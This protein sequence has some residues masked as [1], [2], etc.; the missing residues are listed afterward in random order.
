M[1]DTKMECTRV[2]V[3]INGLGRFGLHLLQYWLDNYDDA[4]FDIVYINDEVLGFEHIK[5]IV[6]TDPY[7]KLSSRINFK[8]NGL[9]EVKNNGLKQEINY[10]TESFNSIPWLGKTSIF[11]ECSGRHTERIDWDRVIADKTKLVI[12]SA[13]SWTAD[14]I[15]VFGHNHKDIDITKRRVV[16]YGSCTVN[17]YVPLADF[18]H[19]K[20]G[21]DNSDVSVIHNIPVYRAQDF[22][23]LERRNC[24]LEK[25]APVVLPFLNADNFIVTYTVVPHTG[26]S[27][28]DFRFKLKQEIS[29]DEIV[30]HLKIAIQTGQ[31]H[32][33]YGIVDIDDGPAA[34]KFTKHSAVLVEPNI[35]VRGHSL[36]IGAYFDNENSANRYFDTINY[37]IAEG[38]NERS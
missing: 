32:G 4:L 30:K 29:R 23:T 17:A 35:H 6:K 25:V 33:I 21:I 37:A 34:H 22:K 9:L 31:L 27:M 3:G 2:K 12:I 26:V 10:T 8:S 11:L 18:I 15:C 28:I 13:T 36:Y 5:E 1:N 19:K 24:T 38:C 7:L 14:C 16:S 20:W